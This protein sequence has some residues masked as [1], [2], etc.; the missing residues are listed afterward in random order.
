[1]RRFSFFL[2]AGLTLHAEIK[3][4]ESE[5][6]TQ[7]EARTYC[8]DLGSGWRQMSIGELFSSSAG[9]REEYSYWSSNQAPS[10]TTVI[11]TG[12][13]GDGG[14]IAMLGYSFYPKEKNI[15]LSTP[16][17]K[18]AA[19]CTNTQFVKE[20]KIY[21]QSSVGIEDKESG[22]LWHSLDATDK[23]AKYSYEKAKEHCETL[24][25]NSKSWR[26]PTLNE[27]YGIVDYSRYRPTVKMSF[28]GPMMHRYYW[29]SDT[30]NE[31]E[32]YV[33]GFKLG[34]VATVSKKEE[35]YVRCVSDQ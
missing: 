9:F 29:T 10:D 7:E 3:L 31:S 23:K 8:R 35:A 27:L 19:A 14:I 24:T 20:K 15:T 1:V 13:E 12:S 2:L 26:I 30:L 17:K 22:I 16:I 6:Y 18:I 21:L 34:S 32:A 11:G 28:F 25:L 4:S 33:V 5:T